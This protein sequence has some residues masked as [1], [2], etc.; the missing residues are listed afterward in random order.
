MNVTFNQADSSLNGVSGF[1]RSSSESFI[2][3]RRRWPGERSPTAP[4]LARRPADFDSAGRWR[5]SAC[6]GASAKRDEFG[7]KAEAMTAIL[8]LRVLMDG[9]VRRWMKGR[10]IESALHFASCIRDGDGAG[11]GE[12]SATAGRQNSTWRIWLSFLRVPDVQVA[13]SGMAVL[14]PTKR[15][16]RAKFTWTSTPWLTSGPDLPNQHLIASPL[17]NWRWSS[18]QLR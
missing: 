7:A 3:T 10:F 18:F 14:R 8:N 17:Q 9:C 2:A 6:A 16:Q 4:K 15:A 5:S 12:I 11:L 13:A 1:A